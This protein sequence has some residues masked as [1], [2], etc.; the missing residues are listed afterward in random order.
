MKVI[1]TLFIMLLAIGTFILAAR[2]CNSKPKADKTMA[3]SEQSA[4]ETLNLQYLHS[5]R[6]QNIKTYTYLVSDAGHPV[7]LGYSAGFGA[8]DSPEGNGMWIML[9]DARTQHA[10]PVYVGRGIVV[11]AFPLN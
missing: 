6:E 9:W 2:F 3:L 11:S 1:K 4:R 8:A 7:F 10:L 5:L